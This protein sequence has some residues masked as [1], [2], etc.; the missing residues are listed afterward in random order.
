M[1]GVQTFQPTSVSEVA[2]E[3]MVDFGVSGAATE[4]LGPYFIQ[5]TSSFQNG[6]PHKWGIL[7]MTVESAKA[8]LDQLQDKIYHRNGVTDGDATYDQIAECLKAK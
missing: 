1:K 5:I 2:D 3:R 6:T 7:S 4:S 8:L